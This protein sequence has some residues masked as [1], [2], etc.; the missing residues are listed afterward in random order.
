[1]DLAFQNG[2]FSARVLTF[3][4]PLSAF[5]HLTNLHCDSLLS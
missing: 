5:L 1:M 4:E 3:A 2:V